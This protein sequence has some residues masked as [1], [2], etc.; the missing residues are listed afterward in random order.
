VHPSSGSPSGVPLLWRAQRDP[1]LLCA[2]Q[3]CTPVSGCSSGA[4]AGCRLGPT[5]LGVQ[6]MAPGP[7]YPRHPLHFLRGVPWGCQAETSP[8]GV[9][10]KE[11]MPS[12]SVGVPQALPLSASAAFSC[13]A[14]M[15]LTQADADLALTSADA[16]KVLTPADADLALAAPRA[17]DLGDGAWG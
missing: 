15:A 12:L 1:A 16:D 8:P 6:G 9:L 3:R 7:A 4:A 17:S 14:S 10:P 13:E 11:P 2:A 5:V